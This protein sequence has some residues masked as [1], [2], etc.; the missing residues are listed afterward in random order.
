MEEKL[1]KFD[2]KVNREVTKLISSLGFE[3]HDNMTLEEEMTLS[4][5]MGARGYAIDIAG[6]TNEGK[7]VVTVNLTRTFELIL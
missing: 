7:Y 2:E 6:D 5:E 4:R 1:E 3:I